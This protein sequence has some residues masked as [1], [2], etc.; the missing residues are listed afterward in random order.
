MS[1]WF[2]VDGKIKSAKLDGSLEGEERQTWWDDK[3][4]FQFDEDEDE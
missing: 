4:K 2:A 3:L 1:L